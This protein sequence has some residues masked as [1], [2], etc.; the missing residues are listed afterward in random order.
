MH[1]GEARHTFYSD[2]PFTYQ[3]DY[4]KISV[5]QFRYYNMCYLTGNAFNWTTLYKINHDEYEEIEETTFSYPAK[6]LPPSPQNIGKSII[7]NP[8]L[9]IEM[10][11]NNIPLTDTSDIPD[12]KD[13][14]ENWWLA[15]KN[16]EVNYEIDLK[17]LL[18]PT[19]LINTFN[20][21]KRFDKSIIFLLQL[22]N[23]K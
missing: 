21:L 1:Q 18:D 8:D 5:A 7:I 13:N 3:G 22:W 17:P 20:V 11:V 16:K 6:I 19:L 23:L 14:T 15:N 10:I 2:N 12:Y 9:K 4:N